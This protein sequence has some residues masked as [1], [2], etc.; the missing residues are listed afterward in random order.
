[1]KKWLKSSIHFKSNVGISK[2]FLSPS[3]SAQLSMFKI[4]EESFNRLMNEI[5]DKNALLAD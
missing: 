1:M 3:V 2:Q 4:K 5:T